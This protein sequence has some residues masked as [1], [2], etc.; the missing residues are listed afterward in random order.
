M[1]NRISILLAVFTLVLSV[2]VLSGC[3]GNNSGN[4]DTS[5]HEHRFYNCIDQ[6]GLTCTQDATKTYKCECGE[7]NVVVTEEAIGSH[8]KSTIIMTEQ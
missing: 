1:K 6:T 8:K 3:F 5:A 7:I 4:G 2:C